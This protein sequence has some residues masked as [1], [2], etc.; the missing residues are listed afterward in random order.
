MAIDIAL[1]KSSGYYDISFT[2]GDFTLT[3]GFDT[4]LQISLFCERRA[5]PSEMPAPQLRRGWW[6][7]LLNDVAG[8]EIGSKLWLLSQARATEDVLNDAIN[9]VEQCLSWLI[10]DTYLTNIVVTGALHEAGITLNIEL[11]RDQDIVA[12]DSFDLWEL[13]GTRA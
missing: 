5:A 3:E 12:S 6:G 2:D 1:T 9:Y 7:N 8:F 10:E 13:T 11:L 4:A